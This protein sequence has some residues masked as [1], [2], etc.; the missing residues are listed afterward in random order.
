MKLLSLYR[1]SLDAALLAAAS[2]CIKDDV[3]VLYEDADGSGERV[4]VRLD[5]KGGAGAG[6]EVRS[7]MLEGSEEV[8]SGAHAYVFYSESGLLDS[9][10]ELSVG[11][12]S[13][14]I[15]VPA[16]NKL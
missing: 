3:P 16:G 7:P 5:I 15:S 1:I 10:Q 13:S 8:M 14:V 2:G 6:I 9:V 11:W 4:S 12:S